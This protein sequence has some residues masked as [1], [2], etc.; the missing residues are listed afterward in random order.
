MKKWRAEQ[1]SPVSG[2]E[3][4]ANGQSGCSLFELADATF[5]PARRLSVVPSRRVPDDQPK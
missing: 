3:L 2:L 1:Q 4:T 5:S